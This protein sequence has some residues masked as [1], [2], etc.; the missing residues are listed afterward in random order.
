MARWSLRVRS[1]RNARG[2]EPAQ[3]SQPLA[4]SGWLD[5]KDPWRTFFPLGGLLGW[6]GVLT[7]LFFGT[8]ATTAHRAVFH[9]T[10]QI[11][12]FLTSMAVGFLYTFVPRRTET[13]PPSRAEMSIAAAAPVLA[14]LAAWLEQWPLAQAFWLS[15][16]AVVAVFVVRRVRSPAGDRRLPG[17]FVWVPVALLSGIIGA[18]LVAIAAVLDPREEPELWQLG[19]GLLLQ[20]LVSGLIVGVGGTLLPTLLR[21]E[22]AA[23]STSGARGRV[24]QTAAALLFL[25]SFPVEVFVAPRWGLALRAAVA[26]LVLAWEA[27]LWRRPSM[28]GL[29]RWFI[30]TSAWLLPAGYVLAALHPALRSAA[31]HVVFIGSFALMAL[32]VSLHVA[33]SHGGSPERLAQW[34]WRTWAMGLLLLAAVVFRVLAG[35]DAGHLVRWLGTAAAAFLLATVAWASSVLPA[36]LRRPARNGPSAR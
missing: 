26:G 30:W 29:H 24:A 20:G 3:R 23:P 11:Q 35:L 33:L 6:A 1:D 13:A 7:W 19:R 15:G 2:A 14:T 8:G 4:L 34:S 17:V 5:A 32:S 10:A 9:A 31:L 21:G 25:A 18:I 28:P 36:I 27:R 16:I 22:T 12:G